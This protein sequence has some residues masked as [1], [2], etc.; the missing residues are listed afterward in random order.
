MDQIKRTLLFW[1]AGE[2]VS[3]S[4]AE[5]ARELRYGEDVAGLNDLPVR[6]IL[7]RIKAEF[8]D[9][10]ENAG[11]L[12]ARAGDGS[13]EATWTWQ[14]VRVDCRELPPADSQ[15]LT[16]ILESFGCT[17]YELDSAP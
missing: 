6:D 1:S 14:Y 2:S 16:R 4:A 12:T 9:H 17:V 15:R 5:I 11:Q 3:L 7:D 10:R 8:P 13:L